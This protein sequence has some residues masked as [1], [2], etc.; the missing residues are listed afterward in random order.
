MINS[1]RRVQ[2]DGC[3]V[4]IIGGGVVGMSL[5][6][7]LIAQGLSVT[8]FDEGDNAFRASRGNFALVW[9]QGKGMGMPEYARWTA[10]SADLW[11]SFAEDLEHEAGMSISYEHRGGIW[12]SLTEDELNT[13]VNDLTKLHTEITGLP[14]F[15]VLDHNQLKA[16]VP[17]IGPEVAGGTYCSADGQTNALRLLAALHKVC[18][19]NG[20]T[21]RPNEQISKID[22][23]SDG[24]S[25]QTHAG[26]FRSRKVVLAA[27]LGNKK[28]APILG[29]TAPIFA[30]RGQVMVTEKLERFLDYPIGEIR[31]TDEGG[32][33]IGVS[34]EDVGLNKR[35]ESK[36]LSKIA[37]RAIRLV[38]FLANVQIVRSWGALRIMSQDGFPIYDKS[39]TCN[40]A[41]LITCHSGITLAAAH[42]RIIA[43]AIAEDMWLDDF[44]PFSARR[45]ADVPASI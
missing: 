23:M 7:G 37:N 29:M 8:V 28:L 24:F 15:E 45:F 27:G 41:Y 20:V 26:E 36:V 22:S 13:R 3:D 39:E 5:A 16:M 38:P 1:N 35:T 10:K 9:V 21:Y 40:G 43:K 4:A 12:L 33:L 14:S 6:Y 30:E 19:E 18:I 31:Q 11:D 44:L 25:I 2:S 32:V 42:A 34:Q 17:E